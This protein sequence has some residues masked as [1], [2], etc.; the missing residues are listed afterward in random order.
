MMGRHTTANW[1]LG[2]FFIIYHRGLRLIMIMLLS[3]YN[4]GETHHC[5]LGMRTILYYLAYMPAP[6]PDNVTIATTQPTTQNNLKQ[7]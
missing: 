1:V 6:D 5:Q 2:Q 3:V 4:D 7:L